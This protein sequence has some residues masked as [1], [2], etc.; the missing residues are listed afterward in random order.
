[1]S[2]CASGSEFT[3]D[4]IRGEYREGPFIGEQGIHRLNEQVKGHCDQGS[5]TITWSKS[6]N[7]TP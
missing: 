1:M 7:R 2:G 6:K 5:P 4:A 3:G